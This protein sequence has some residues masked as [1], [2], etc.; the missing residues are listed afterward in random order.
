MS[1]INE[2]NSGYVGN[3][4]NLTREEWDAHVEEL[5]RTL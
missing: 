3:I 2:S 1:L 4:K 5:W